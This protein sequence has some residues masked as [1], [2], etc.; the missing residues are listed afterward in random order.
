VYLFSEKFLEDLVA[1]VTGP[2]SFRFI[3]QPAI[4]VALGIRDG[5]MDAKAGLPP[6]IYDLVFKPK[7]RE[8]QLKSALHRLLTP[9]ILATILDAIAQYL[10]SKQIRPLMAL[11]VGT[12][13]MGLPYA[14]ARA[15][16]NRIAS[17]LRSAPG[18]PPTAQ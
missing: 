4:A 11:L 17:R 5:L 9:I 18:S 14:V 15:I 2:M 16:T 10:I 1:R 3:L 7:D 6:F 13:V 12:F 8:R